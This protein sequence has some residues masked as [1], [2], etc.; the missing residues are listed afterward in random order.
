MFDSL[1][2]LLTSLD[3]WVAFKQIVGDVSE[4][5]LPKNVDFFHS[6]WFYF[7][8]KR[9]FGKKRVAQ[10]LQKQSE[11]SPYICVYYETAKKWNN[12]FQVREDIPIP[13]LDEVLDAAK[14]PFGGR[15]IGMR[16]SRNAKP[17]DLEKLAQAAMNELDA[18]V[19]TE[20]LWGFR[21]NSRYALSDSK[22]YGY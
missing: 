6:D 21:R 18:G 22:R 17:E 10:Y 20:L 3:G 12:Y 19:Q 1:C 8:S 2:V 13:A 4:F 15:G 5:L 9:K 16:F 11:Q 7:N 14:R